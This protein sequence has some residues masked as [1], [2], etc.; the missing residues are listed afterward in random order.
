LLVLGRG[1]N[2]VV[3]DRG[4]PGLVLRL[5]GDFARVT[6]GEVVGGGGGASMPQL[7]RAAA[8]GERLGL[9]FMVGIPGSVGGGVRQN[10]GCFGTEV[11]DVLVK[12]EI[13]DFADRTLKT[14]APAQLTMEYRHTNLSSGQVVVGATFAT[15]AGRTEVGEARM[16]EVTRWRRQH[17]PGGTLN[18]GSVFKN[19][20]GDA[21]G[22]LIDVSG[23]KGLTR[24]G[25]SVSDKHAN[26]FVAKPGTAARDLYRL[27]MDVA[28]RVEAATGI[29][30]EA[31]IQ[32]V[33]DFHEDGAF[34]E[35]SDG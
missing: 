7:A 14:K 24:G 19:P 32:F 30:L 9:E 26:F 35:S 8:R 11:V 34:E 18:A 22:R 21:A 12:A 25:A 3:S 13:F 10:A 17:Q 2:L 33:G 31:E 4:F 28:D 29:R 16:R 15:E 23:L 5:E 27:V 6:I 20:P 1:S